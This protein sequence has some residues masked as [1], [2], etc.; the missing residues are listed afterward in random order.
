MSLKKESWLA[1]S[2]TSHDANSLLDASEDN[3][4]GIQNRVEGALYFL[5]KLQHQHVLI[6]VLSAHLHAILERPESGSPVRPLLRNV[7]EALV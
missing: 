4:L 7:H 6:V 3:V 2:I 5:I 1:T